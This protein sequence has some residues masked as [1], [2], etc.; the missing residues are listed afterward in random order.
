[1]KSLT[2]VLAAIVTVGLLIAAGDPRPAIQDATR[3]GDEKAIR[4]LLRDL[5]ERW[6][7][8]EMKAFG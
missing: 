8:H 4:T 3:E 1:M 6:N 2:L 5:E 7:K